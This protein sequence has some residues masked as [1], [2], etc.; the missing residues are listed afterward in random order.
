MKKETVCKTKYGY[1]SADGLEY[2][3]TQPETPKPWVNH[4]TN[5]HYCS[6]VSHTGGGYSFVDDSGYNRILREY[7]GEELITDRPGRYVYI[8]DNQTGEFWSLGWQPVRRQPDFW[9]CRHGLGYT[10]ITSV[11][12]EI[13]GNLRFFVPRKG[14]LE[15]WTIRLKNLS[16]KKRDLSIIT[17]VEWCL[18]NYQSDLVDRSFDVLFNQTE[19]E[20]NILFA[21][22]KRWIRPDRQDLTWDKTAFIFSSLGSDG[23]DCS[24][25]DFLGPY[26]YLDSPRAIEEGKCRNSQGQGED[27]VGVLMKRVEIN[28]GQELIFD[29]CLGVDSDKEKIKDTCRTFSS[30]E[31]VEKEWEDLSHYWREYL[32][33]IRV[34]TPDP[35]F[36]VSVNIWNK[37]QA[38]VTPHWSEM[39]SYY[40][41]GGATYG[42]RDECQHILGI[43]P[44]DAGFVKKKLV[45]LVE[46]QFVDGKVF[47]NFDVLTDDGSVTGHAD[48]CQWLVMAILNYLDETGDL[49]FL[50][51]KINYYDIGEGT[52]LEHLLRALDYTITN[53]SHRGLAFHRTADWN[54][55]LAGG[56]L[57]RGESMMVSN[58]VCWNI[59]RLLPLL[60]TID[61]VD[62]KD[63][64]QKIYN[65]IKDALNNYCWDDEWYIRATTDDGTPIGSFRNQEGKIF[66]DGQIWAVLSGVADQ[67]RG[68]QAMNAVEKHLNTPYGPCLFLP[69]YT[70]LNNALG[71]I[72][73]FAPGTKEN[74]TIFNHPVAWAV[75]AE[76]ILGRGE[77]AYGYW[78]KTSFMTRGKDPDLY[79]AEPYVWA[80]FVYG[81][82]NHLFGEGSF[83][84]TTGSAAWFFRA[85]LD[86]ILGVRPTIKGLLIDPCIPPDWKEFKVVR[87][88]R[89]AVYEIEVSNPEK[90]SKGIK[91]IEVDGQEVK[92][93]LLPD[94]GEGKH[95]VKAIMGKNKT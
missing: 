20:D 82:Q 35:E 19:F 25:R 59:S 16:W 44:H 11:N 95:Q 92:D 14:L 43:L 26:H 66:L 54:D 30:R 27:S 72:S 57:G 87:E 39:D 64:Y 15:F 50:E 86:W 12:Q 47:H 4:L 68:E 49:A 73:Q 24:K 7:P 13:Q 36:D 94:F 37:Y 1:F 46:H 56:K 31:A 45:Y 40:I 67:G 33:K 51:K 60:L 41:S 48:D 29:V 83:T 32:Q 2:V 55:A 61:Q 76:C 34:E 71:I 23:F 90:I 52:V 78:Q 10:Q 81:P 65:E 80:E 18:G 93:C 53:R 85:C 70:R 21:T 69:A 17:Y 88:F 84:W 58:M 74:G 77:K 63:K 3:I 8:R 38:W 75:I 5:E 28:E 22:K 89:G 42:F 9:E 6:L 79:K 62:Y 91:R